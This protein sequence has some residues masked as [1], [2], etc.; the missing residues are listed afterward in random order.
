MPPLQ[1]L[2]RLASRGSVRLPHQT[3]RKFQSSTS[4]GCWGHCHPAPRPFTTG[5]RVH[6]GGVDDSSCTCPQAP[7][8]RQTLLSPRHPPSEPD[9][10]R[11]SQ[12]TSLLEKVSMLPGR[13]LEHSWLRSNIPE[14]EERS[15]HFSYSL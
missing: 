9:P 7:S 5:A 1:G 11:K 3:R 15:W 2:W 12:T 4:D 8:P 14:N 10:R 6:L 13:T